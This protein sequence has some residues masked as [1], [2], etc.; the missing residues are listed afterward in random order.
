MR[1]PAAE[2][3]E[4]IRL[5][6]ASH[7]PASRTLDKLGIPRSTFYRWYDRYRDSGPEALGDRRSRPDRVWN[8]IP[9]VIRDEIIHLALT[10]P[11]LSPRELA[12][13]FTD[14]PRSS[15]TRPRRQTSFGRPTSPTSRSSAGAGIISLPYST[16]SPASSSPGN[17]VRPCGPRT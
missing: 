9:E 1:Y 17:S 3:V 2:K 5:V 11:E 7:L 14:E 6:E 12:V 13:R 15:R 8:R 16:T 10:L 4:I